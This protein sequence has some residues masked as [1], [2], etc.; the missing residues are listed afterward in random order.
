MQAS[1][2]LEIITLLLLGRGTITAREL[3]VRFGVSQRTSSRDIEYLF[4]A[5]VYMTKG[6]S[7]GISLL[8]GYAM[9]KALLTREDQE[10][11]SLALQ[12]HRQPAGLGSPPWLNWVG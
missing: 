11:I 9:N 2:L 10:T 1:R 7:G 6:R 12:T 5:P 8:P 4:G 3:A